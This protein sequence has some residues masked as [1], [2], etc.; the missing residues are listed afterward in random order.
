MVTQITV[1]VFVIVG[2]VLLGLFTAVVP[3]LQCDVRK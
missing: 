1:D 3:K 2:V